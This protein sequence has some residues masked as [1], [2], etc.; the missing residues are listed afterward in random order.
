MK[1]KTPLLHNFVCLKPF[2]VQVR[3]NLCFK[4][5]ISSEE[6]V[7]LNVLYYQQLSFARH[8]VVFMLT[9]ILSNYQ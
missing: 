6:A 1:E 3:I 2:N 4:N 7:S 5:Y 8:Q 9:F